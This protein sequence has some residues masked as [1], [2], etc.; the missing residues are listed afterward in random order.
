MPKK[1]AVFNSAWHTISCNVVVWSRILFGLCMILAIAYLLLQRSPNCKQMMPVTQ[2]VLLLGFMCGIA[3][4]F[5]V[6]TLGGSG[7]KWLIHWEALCFIHFLAN[8]C[9][10]TFFMLLHGPVFVSQGLHTKSRLPYWL[11]RF[12]FYAV[13]LVLPI[14]CG[15]MPFAGPGD[16]KDHIVSLGTNMLL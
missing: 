9:T 7:Y 15:L 6:D 11:R 4:K 13:V 10:S 5:C 12:V 3:G 16:W 8:V 1:V 14:C 2:I